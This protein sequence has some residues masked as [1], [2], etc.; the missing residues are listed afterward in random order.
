MS[1]DRG[2]KMLPSRSQFKPEEVTNWILSNV[3]AILALEA[4]AQ[5]PV[6]EYVNQS[7]EWETLTY[8]F[9]KAKP[10]LARL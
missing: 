6:E 3:G 4:R 2:S 1:F 7:P 8:S 9:K 10:E 5:F